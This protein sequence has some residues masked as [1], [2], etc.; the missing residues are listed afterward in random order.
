VLLRLGEDAREEEINI[1]LDFL[2]IE[3]LFSPRSFWKWG[4][5]NY[6]GVSRILATS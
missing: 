2:F 1:G 3:D 4:C 6:S 5:C